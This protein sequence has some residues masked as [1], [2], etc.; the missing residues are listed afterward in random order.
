MFETFPLSVETQTPQELKAILSKKPVLKEM[1]ERMPLETLRKIPHSR[2]DSTVKPPSNKAAMVDTFSQLLTFSSQEAFNS[3]ITLFPPL[4]QEMLRDAALF[5]YGVLEK[6]AAKSKQPLLP[7]KTRYYS[8][9]IT[10][11]PWLKLAFITVVANLN[12]IVFFL[13]AVFRDALKP[14]FVPPPDASLDYCAAGSKD[15]P[16]GSPPDAVYSNAL[17][18]VGS[19]PLLCEALPESFSEALEND[20]SPGSMRSFTKKQLTVLKARCGFKSFPMVYEKTPD[21]LD[22]A[23]RF[24]LSM[25]NFKPKRP[26]DGQDGVKKIVEAF[27]A[28]DAKNK[29]NLDDYDSF[30]WDYIENRILTAHLRKKS[31]NW[32][33]FRGPPW[34]RK[35]FQNIF[36]MIAQDGRWFSALKLARFISINESLFTFVSLKTEDRLL[37]KAS[38]II[39][40]GVTYKDEYGDAEIWPFASF[41]FELLIRPLFYAYCYLFAA[42]GL[43]EITQ[44]TPPEPV[45]SGSKPKP[46]SMYDALDAVRVTGLGRWCLGLTAERPGRIQ[47]KY[48]AI[49]DKELLLVTVRGSSFERAVYLDSIGEK[50]GEDRWR[51]SPRS[52]VAGCVKKQEIEE[53]VKRF[54]R[55]IDAKPAPHW[56]ALFSKALERAGFLNTNII[57]ATVFYVGDNRS[58]IEELLKDPGLSS[59]ALRAE[60]GMLVVPDKQRKKFLDLLAEHGVVC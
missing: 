33:Y 44:K 5:G 14:W 6:Y 8:W 49:A 34:S 3:W 50:L 60:G 41:R 29:K 4:A 59:C 26:E 53:R 16:D 13:P 46:V 51:I 27:F 1:L 7:E 47:E 15:A 31:L 39:I 54:K 40:D 22:L 11:Q 45:I 30:K 36:T 28:I 10:L 9:D 48:E 43:L 35:V 25:T 2:G 38:S 23:A 57:Q 56:E 32:G 18:I 20:E 12:Q 42:L 24:V 58:L 17:E 52:F 37:Y 19:F 21:S 55:L